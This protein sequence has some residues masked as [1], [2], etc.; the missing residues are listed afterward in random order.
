[1]VKMRTLNIFIL[2]RIVK[3]GNLNKMI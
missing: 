3:M 2:N 1:M